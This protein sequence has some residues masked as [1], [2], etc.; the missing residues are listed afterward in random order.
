MEFDPWSALSEAAALRRHRPA[1]RKGS[2]KEPDHLADIFFVPA[3]RQV[4]GCLFETTDYP[5][6]QRATFQ[7]DSSPL[8]SGHG[9]FVEPDQAI[10]AQND[11]DALILI[12]H[13]PY[14]GIGAWTRQD[15]ETQTGPNT[16]L[17][18]SA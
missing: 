8:S 18:I 17:H 4:Q 3:M 7:R 1:G 15:A 13:T 10:T 2:Q 14:I 6:Q 16:H 12:F 11:V 9:L 5:T